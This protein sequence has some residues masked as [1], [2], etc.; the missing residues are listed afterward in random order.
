MFGSLGPQEQLSEY[1][2]RGQ[3]LVRLGGA[4]E[5]EAAGDARV[6][7]PGR[8]RLEDGGERPC[9]RGHDFFVL[10]ARL[11]P[12]ELAVVID[13]LRVGLW[14]HHMLHGSRAVSSELFSQAIGLMSKALSPR[15][16]TAQ[17]GAAI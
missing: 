3:P 4:R 16:G 8:D 1:A 5:L 10:R 15:A 2:A 7:A 17:V 6:E 9:A 12:Q 14:S 11:T 13:A